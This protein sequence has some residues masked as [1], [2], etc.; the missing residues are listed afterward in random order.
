MKKK[1]LITL[2]CSHTQGLGCWDMNLRYPVGFNAR[3]TN[4][5]DWAHVNRKRFHE[6]GWPNRLGKKLG[7]DKVINLGLGGS[8]TSAQ[9][10][11]FMLKYADEKF[12]EYEVLVSWLITESVRTSFFRDG[13]CES[14]L[15]NGFDEDKITLFDSIYKFISKNGTRT[16]T[17]TTLDYVR[18]EYINRKVVKTICE[19]KGWNFIS[20]HTQTHQ[21]GNIIQHV[22]GDDKT[23]SF[24]DIGFSQENDENLISKYC[25]HFN[26]DGYEMISNKMVNWIKS[27]H[28]HL[29]SNSPKD[30]IEWEWDGEFS[31]KL[32]KL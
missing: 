13:V 6:L 17:H 28:P 18:E 1:L 8:S 20:F 2:G 21:Y 32:E 25:G 24:T 22:Y 10:K 23:H 4:F 5:G 9:L 30:E 14:L 31:F 27:N 19:L 3:H 11:R 29:L 12:S 16:E 15:A 7:Y 26:E